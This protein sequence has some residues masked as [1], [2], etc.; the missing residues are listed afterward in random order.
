MSSLTSSC[1]GERTPTPP[2]PSSCPHLRCSLCPC[3]HPRDGHAPTLSASPSHPLPQNSTRS[4]EEL[5]ATMSVELLSDFD[6]ADFVA[7]QAIMDAAS[8]AEK[9]GKGGLI[10][11]TSGSPGPAWRCTLPCRIQC[12]AACGCPAGSAA[13]PACPPPPPAS[14]HPSLP[15]SHQA[16]HGSDCVLPDRPARLPAAAPLICARCNGCCH[17]C[18]HGCCVNQPTRHAAVLQEPGGHGAS[19]RAGHVAIACTHGK[20]PTLFAVV[21]GCQ[22][23]S[24]AHPATTF[25][26]TPLLLPSTSMLRL[27]GPDW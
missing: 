21:E 23:P 16:G 15:C 3:L 17:G 11:G 19:A 18:R 10:H 1:A 2:P 8:S 12:L 4:C 9:R 5:V 13:C 20:R 7:T 22:P 27:P 24:G 26:L 6:L 25:V 14:T